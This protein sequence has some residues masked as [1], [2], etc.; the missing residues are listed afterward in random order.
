[1]KWSGLG[2]F[3]DRLR[4]AHQMIVVRHLEP[5]VDQWQRA[6][7]QEGGAGVRGAAHAQHDRGTRHGVDLLNEQIRAT[8]SVPRQ[9]S[10]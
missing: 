10:R 5:L 1:M 2:R 9:Q 6:D 3:A 7:I 8:I 4:S